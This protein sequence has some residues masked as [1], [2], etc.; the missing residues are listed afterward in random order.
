MT[1]EAHPPL[2][3]E[4]ETS[5]MG[6]VDLPGPRGTFVKFSRSLVNYCKTHEYIV[7]INTS[8]KAVSMVSMSTLMTQ[9]SEMGVRIGHHLLLCT[10]SSF[11]DTIFILK[12]VNVYDATFSR[13]T[14]LLNDHP[15]R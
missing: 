6:P 3:Q 8:E 9:T 13:L 4:I 11:L 5:V 7:K 12:S 2:G 1:Y 14:A 10:I 15:S